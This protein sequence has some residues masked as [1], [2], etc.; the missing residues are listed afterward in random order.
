MKMTNIK[1][2]LLLGTAA[3]AAACSS[4]FLETE[5]TDR[6]PG[7][8]QEAIL[9]DSPEKIAA[10]IN[11]AYVTIY[12]GSPLIGGTDARGL[13]SYLLAM[14]MMCEDIADYTNAGTYAYDQQLIFREPNYRRPVSM[15]RQFYY[16]ISSLNSVIGTLNSGEGTSDDIDAMLGQALA[17]RS[18]AYYWLV[19][20]WQHPYSAD[21]EAPGVPLYVEDATKNILSRAS[22][23]TIYEQMD[24]D[25]AK[26][27]T[28]LKGKNVGKTGINE[29]AAAGIYANVLMFM[30]RYGDAATQ[31][32]HAT[33]GGTLADAAGL[34]S[35]FN[36]LSMSEVLWGYEV[37]EEW[38]MVYASF[39]SMINPYVDG[40]AVPGYYPKLGASALVDAIDANDVRKAW[41][42]YKEELVSAPEIISFQMIEDD[43]FAAYVPN[44]FLCPTSFMADMIYMRV[45]EMYFVAAEAHY[46][47]NDEA[48]ARK[49]LTDIMSTRIPGYDASGKSSDALYEEICFQ[50]R[51]EMW[52]EGCRIFDAKRRNETIDRTESTNFP[53]S[54]ASVQALA[55]YSARDYRMIYKIPLNELENNDSI[56]EADQNP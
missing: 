48:K 42:G 37:T 21:P 40:Y 41:F 7:D 15:W 47:N 36:S 16:I 33:K 34:T 4:D 32:E 31:A 1:S 28:L 24:T 50:K 26:A 8:R 45:A 5:P 39:M 43:G 55:P 2:L 11:G 35:G 56:T 22:V 19:N 25:L 23:K 13:T 6:V 54:L 44:K 52:G 10:V 9:L 30:G 51:V 46:L 27:C 49:A 29:Y 20:M 12:S 17:L 53:A 18:Y 38:N 3:L 14:D